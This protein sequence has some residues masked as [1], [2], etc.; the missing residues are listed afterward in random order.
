M[1]ALCQGWYGLIGG[2]WEVGEVVPLMHF[3][4]RRSEEYYD[5]MI[6]MKIVRDWAL[7]GRGRKLS[8]SDPLFSVRW[9]H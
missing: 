1:G 4:S 3:H 8:L 5:S 9:A 2:V 7:Q 6:K